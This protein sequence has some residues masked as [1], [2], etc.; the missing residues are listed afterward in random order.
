MMAAMTAFGLLGLPVRFALDSETLTTHWQKAIVLVHPDRFAG[1]SD[2][3]KR[4]AQQWAGRINDAKALLANPVTRAAEI[5]RLAGVELDAETDTKMPADFLMQQM[6]W[7]EMAEEEDQR[8]G[9]VAEVRQAMDAE[10][11]VLTQALDTDKDYLRARDSARR[12]LFIQKLA[13]QV[14]IPLK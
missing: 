14:N 11:E 9:L 5:L 10:I 6:A 2:A 12:L 4:V 3:E 13:T 7:R 1:R 8:D